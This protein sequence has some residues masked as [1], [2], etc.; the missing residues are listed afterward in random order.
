MVQNGTQRRMSSDERRAE[1]LLAAHAVF[2]ARGYEGATTDEVARAAFSVPQRRACQAAVPHPG[3]LGGGAI[4]RRVP[5]E[6]SDATDELQRTSAK[7]VRVESSRAAEGGGR[8]HV[9]G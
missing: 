4:S 3:E 2:G 8:A 1:I 6:A 5:A 7:R 9:M